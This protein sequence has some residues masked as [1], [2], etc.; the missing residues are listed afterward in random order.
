VLFLI[1]VIINYVAR[2]VVSRA[3]ARLKG[4]AA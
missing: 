3:E 2:I 1:T 4:A